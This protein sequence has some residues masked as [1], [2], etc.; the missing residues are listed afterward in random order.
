[1]CNKLC[2]C[3]LC[4]YA[5][6]VGIRI[7]RN[8]NSNNNNKTFTTK[9]EN[10]RPACSITLCVV[11]ACETYKIRFLAWNR[12][13]LL[14]CSQISTTKELEA[15]DKIRSKSAR[16]HRANQSHLTSYQLFVPVYMVLVRWFLY[17]CFVC[18]FKIICKSWSNSGKKTRKDST[19]E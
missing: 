8:K 15:R 10:Q 9:K 1:M 17:F 7:V 16:T 2:Q 14:S 13:R 5:V 12:S 19:T 18:K 11:A 3:V 4:L 6:Y